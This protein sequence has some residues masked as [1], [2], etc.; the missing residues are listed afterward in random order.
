M[1]TGHGQQSPRFS[2][3]H[4]ISPL[5]LPQNL[6]SISAAAASSIRVSGIRG[7]SGLGWALRGFL[8]DEAAGLAV[9]RRP[10]SGGLGSGRTLGP[11][12]WGPG[13][14]HRS[15]QGKSK[16]RSVARTEKHNR[17]YLVLLKTETQKWQSA[18]PP[19]YSCGQS[20]SHGDAHC[21]RTGL[22]DSACMRPRRGC[23]ANCHSRIEHCGH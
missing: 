14:R 7:P 5:P 11:S 6:P 15:S 4:L 12:C 16:A 20:T 17:Q 18:F 10:P 19:R 13:C 8:P 2:I 9:L 23:D 22:R 21:Q 3:P 1:D